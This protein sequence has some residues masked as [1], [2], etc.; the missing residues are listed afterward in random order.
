MGRLYV[1]V[2]RS[3]NL[4][5]KILVFVVYFSKCFHIKQLNWKIFYFWHVSAISIV[6]FCLWLSILQLSKCVYSQM[7]SLV[8]GVHATSCFYGGFF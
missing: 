5:S 7:Q 6:D 4:R 1:V 3:Q 8:K 2:K